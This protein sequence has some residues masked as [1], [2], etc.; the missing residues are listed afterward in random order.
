V[1]TLLALAGCASLD[2]RGAFEDVAQRLG[3]RTRGDLTWERQ[4]R[5]REA[6]D[7]RV[8]ELL[9]AGLTPESAVQLALLRNRSLQAVLLRLGIAQAELVQAGLLRNPVL[10][11]NVRFGTGPSG[12]GTELGLVQEF[13]SAIQIPLRR[14]VARAELEATKLEVGSAAFELVVAVRS[15]FYEAQGA[16]QML[17][18][19]R[20][21]MHTLELAADVAREQH[22][23]G[24]ITDLD[25]AQQEAFLHES[26]L[27]LAEDELDAFDR[28]E[29]L[30]LLI[31]LWGEEA[32]WSIGTRLPALPD[33]EPGPA[34]LETL[35]VE[36]RLDLA[37]SRQRG[38]AA[39][40]RVRL[41]RFFGLIPEGGGGVASEREVEG[42][43]SVGPALEVPIPLFDF[44]Q[45]QLAKARTR[46]L[47]REERFT[48]LAVAVRSEVRRAWAE[49]DV[50]RR[51]ARYHESMMLPLRRTILQQTQLEY[52]GMV[53]G[54]FQLL[55]AKRGEIEAGV[56]YVES[57]RDYWV[58]RV[59]LERA[60]GTELRA[61]EA[62][63][64]PEATPE[65]T[66][67]EA[68][69]HPHHHGHGG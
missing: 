14:R 30:T 56:D 45:A 15:A 60:L 20:T 47:E 17:E 67:G 2:P 68:P 31:G 64:S 41:R 65:T 24:N 12:T 28:R 55:E 19:R 54:V 69:E 46:Q 29:A 4:D 6:V 42:G 48:A 3:E 21:A 11:A 25:L 23:A 36:R 43:W 59:D 32:R 51:R 16:E 22:R 52:N 49:L 66:P 33:E 35:A 7:A 50:A 27:A 37:A 39:S 61:P 44:G 9:T 8:R 53:V 13:V 10:S 34:G 5:A 1:L 26:R 58:A 62:T 40:E 38:S 18:L 57:L 63:P